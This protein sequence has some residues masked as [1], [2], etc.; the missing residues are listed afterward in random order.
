MIQAI[1][2]RDFAKE[3]RKGIDGTYAN[4]PYQLQAD[5]SQKE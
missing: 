4:K 2:S 3:S 1:F 5:Q